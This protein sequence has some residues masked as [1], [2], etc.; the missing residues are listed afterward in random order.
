VQTIYHPVGT[1]RVGE[2]SAAVVDNH[3]RVHG[4]E[5]LFITDASVLDR[6]PSCNPSA[7]IMALAILAAERIEDCFV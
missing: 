3:F 5:G 4:L 1:C 7:Q 6:I 2:D